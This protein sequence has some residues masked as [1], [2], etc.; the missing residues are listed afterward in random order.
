ML[1]RGA[2]VALGRYR[3][4]TPE[5]VRFRGA[6]A[7][8]EEALRNVRGGKLKGYDNDAVTEVSKALMQ[9]V[10]LWDYPVLY[11]LQRLSPEITRVVD[12]GGHIGVKYRAF[13]PYLDLGRLDWVVYD[14]PA[15]VRAGQA[16]ARPGDRTLSFVDRI[17]DAPPA[18][19]LL[20]SGLLP[21]LATPLAD[22]IGRMRQP[23]RHVLLNKVVTRDG[24]TVVTLEN[25]VVA[26][27]PYHIR[28]VRET[29]MVLESLGY[30][31]VDEWTIDS[32][33]H[34]IETHP[35]LGRGI[36]HGYAARMRK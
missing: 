13:G 21:Y 17:E 10:P 9:Q 33:N 29:P 28:D 24:P 1:R 34:G 18:D 23:P 22:L 11:W 26:E 4:L 12:A 8:H 15:L 5:S 30:D 3:A 35:E 19:V 7:S 14:L 2:K 31:I 36:Y 27:V 16:Q 6:F 20:A 32:L 25:F